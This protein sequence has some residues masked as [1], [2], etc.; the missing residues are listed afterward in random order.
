MS[1]TLRQVLD[2]VST[3]SGMLAPTTWT[4]SNNV[5]DKQ[6]VGLANLAILYLREKRF[7]AQ[8]RSYTYTLSAATIYAPPADLLAFEPD[9]MWA[10]NTIWKVDFP[11]DPTAWAYLKASA[12]P[13]GVVIQ[14][15]YINNFIEVYQ[16][17]ADIEIGVEYYTKDCVISGGVPQELFTTDNDTS[18]FDDSLMIAEIKWRYKKEKGFPDWEVDFKLAQN[19]LNTVLGRDR[20]AQTINPVDPYS[21][22]PYANL[23]AFDT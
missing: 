15:R 13:A 2:L 16:P 11:T 21:P 22:S 23:W 4:G 17:T 6:V 5:A 10:Q 8:I 3:T 7:Q 1:L 20:A 14:A 9:T 12:G 18:I 19:Q